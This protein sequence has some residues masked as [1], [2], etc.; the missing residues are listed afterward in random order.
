MATC[1][2]AHDAF[3]KATSAT[4]DKEAWKAINDTLTTPEAQKHFTGQS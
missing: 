1:L 3:L 2:L 4:S